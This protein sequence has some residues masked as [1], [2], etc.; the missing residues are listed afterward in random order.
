MWSYFVC[1]RRGSR[2]EGCN[3]T[4]GRKTYI[5]FPSWISKKTK[6]TSYAARGLV[7]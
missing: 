4:T 7:S 6:R 3:K 1:V 5:E 2:S